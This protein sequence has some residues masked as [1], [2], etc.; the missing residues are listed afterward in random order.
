[1]PAT[2]SPVLPLGAA[3]L[4][5]GCGAGSLS[6][7]RLR[8]DAGVDRGPSTTPDGAPSASKD[9]E[10]CDNQLDDD[11]D[12]WVDE[13]CPCDSALNQGQQACYSGPIA[14][15]AKGAC[16]DGR[17]RCVGDQEF[18]GWGRCS[19]EVT[20]QPEVDGDGID[21][22]CDGQVD[23]AV[24]CADRPAHPSC[25]C[26]HPWGGGRI[27]HGG[28]LEAWAASTAPC[29]GTCLK[30]TRKCQNGV[31]SGGPAFE[32]CSFAFCVT[33]PAQTL[34]APTD[35]PGVT[36]TD[37]MEEAYAGDEHYSPRP[38][39]VPGQRCRGPA[40]SLMGN[41]CDDTSYRG[42]VVGGRYGTCQNWCA[43]RARCNN[44]RTWTVTG[45]TW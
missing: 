25:S 19:D 34:T 33:C 28:Q 22:D 14:T 26:A 40:C 15:R 11:R 1:M 9:K 12:G 4:L 30:E 7:P 16:H 43:V 42:T 23:Q 35:Q 3:L 5:L 13:G 41:V 27:P 45:W 17:Q 8:P 31:L 6:D 21:N 36:C 44:D 39:G 20:P 10:L 37:T 24:S 38:N 18:K 29:G 32:T 2:F